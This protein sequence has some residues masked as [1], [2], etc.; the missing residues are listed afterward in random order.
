MLIKDVS[1]IGSGQL[2]KG[3]DILIADNKISK[4]GRDLRDDSREDAILGH[5][6]LAIPGLV[7]SHTHLA[8]TL[9][10][11]YADDM[12]LMPWLQEKIWPL[13]ARLTA[14]DIHW[15]VKLGCLE[16]IRFGITCYNDMYYF[17]DETALA[18]KQM[19]LRAFLSGVVFDSQPGFKAEAER[20][21]HNWKGDDLIH[22]AVGPHAIYTC[23]EETLSW[24]RETAEKN[25]IMIHT[26]LSETRGEVEES[27]KKH[28]C[29]PVE[30]LDTLGLLG[31]GLL[32]AHCVWLSEKDTVLLAQHGVNVCHCP[33]SN[34]K[35]AS[36]IAPVERLLT[37]GVNV[38][39][40]TDGA[41][42]NNNLG[43]FDDIK[44]AA[45]VQKYACSRPDALAARLVWTMAT[46][47][48]YRAFGLNVGLHEGALA[49]L[50][51]IDL[52]KPWFT[53]Q[54]NILSHL[55]Y[56]MAGGVD[57]TIVDGKVLMRDGVIPGEALI[58]EKAQKCFERL[59][60]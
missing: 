3:C 36:G 51:L 43:L 13:E 50:A 47:N 8:M 26:H 46:E 28:G 17:M 15:G 39:L 7:N 9:L 44:V 56:S 11:G 23:S 1:L 22:P 52:E 12:P 40:G 27:K 37:S 58:L 16:L 42:S 31:P 32:A 48:A 19:G 21:I 55:V 38:C 60:S 10:R 29:S 54:S 14:E 45:I 49:D 24:A 53:P 41:A 20:F 18:T 34:L 59:T 6:K 57:T 2:L 30:Y 5:G 35:L 4:I 33:I 25:G